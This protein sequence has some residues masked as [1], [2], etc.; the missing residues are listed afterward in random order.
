MKKQFII[1]IVLV[2]LAAAA[3]VFYNFF[4]VLSPAGETTLTSGDLTVTVTYSRPSVRDRL[5]FGSADQ[6]RCNLTGSIG[7]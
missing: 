2:V 1:I 3:V 5:I 6:G 4:S 7:G